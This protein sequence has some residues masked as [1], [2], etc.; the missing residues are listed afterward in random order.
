[1]Q[2]KSATQRKVLRT[3]DAGRIIIT[4]IVEIASADLKVLLIVMS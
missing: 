4:F 2:Y 3:T 1:M